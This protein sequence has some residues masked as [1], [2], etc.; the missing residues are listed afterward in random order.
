MRTVTSQREREK[1]RERERERCAFMQFSLC[2]S[3]SLS[4]REQGAYTIFIGHIERKKDRERE[5]EREREKEKEKE[6]ESE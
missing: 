5:R 1:E 6:G 2:V 4:N 3:H